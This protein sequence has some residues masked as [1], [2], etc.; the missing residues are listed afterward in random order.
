MSLLSFSK[1][2]GIKS[3][4]EIIIWR[5]NKD[6]KDLN[7]LL[8]NP[9]VEVFIVHRIANGESIIKTSTRIYLNEKLKIK[10]KDEKESIA[11]K[12]PFRES[13]SKLEK[14]E[15]SNKDSSVWKEISLLK[16]FLPREQK[17]ELM[18]DVADIKNLHIDRE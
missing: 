14:L 13:I 9:T 3:I 16:T 11:L 12:I 1:V 15:L 18:R 4:I 7:Q 2:Y 17:N 10:A 6:N 5:I 8:K